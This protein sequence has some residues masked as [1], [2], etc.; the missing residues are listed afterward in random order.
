M[1]DKKETSF[2]STKI[3]KNKML[4][5]TMEYQKQTFQEIHYLI[6]TIKCLLRR[7]LNGFEIFYACVL[8][9]LI[10]SNFQSL[11]EFLR[12]IF[13]LNILLYFFALYTFKFFLLNIFISI[14][15]TY[16]YFKNFQLLSISISFCV[17]FYFKL[18]LEI[19]HFHVYKTEMLNASFA[20]SSKEMRN[21]ELLPYK[22]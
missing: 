5:S 6:L 2:L 15:V 1:V 9:A 12:S 21:L 13:V 20:T 10:Q 19:V 17:N 7:C 14:L 22:Y 8:F 18:S 3:L 16:N 11:Y 4:I